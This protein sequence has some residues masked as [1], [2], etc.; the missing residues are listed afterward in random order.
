M[1]GD[2]GHTHGHQ[3][4]VMTQRMLRPTLS[5]SRYK[6]RNEV[7]GTADTL[8]LTSHD[9]S[10]TSCVPAERTGRGLV[11]SR[12]AHTALRFVCSAFDRS[13]LCNGQAGQPVGEGSS[14]FSFSATS[15]WVEH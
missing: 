8:L 11:E 15:S 14:P 1:R 4:W 13:R 9:C 3:G 6:K 12:L 10:V 2:G 7:R 5:F